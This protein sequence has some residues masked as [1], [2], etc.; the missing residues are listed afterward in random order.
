MREGGCWIFLSHSTKDIDMIRRIRNEFEILGQNPIAFH[1]RCL[2]EEYP[3]RD[4]ELWSLIHREI[5]AREWFVYCKSPDAEASEN[6][7]KERM[8]FDISGKNKIWDIDITKGWNEIKNKIHKICAD[9]EVVV[10]YSHYDEAVADVIIRVL[11]DADYAV[12]TDKNLKMDESWIL[13]NNNAI[14]RCARKGFYVV[15]ISNESIKSRYV[16]KEL[17][18]AISQGAWIIPVLV[19]NPMMPEWMRMWLGNCYVCSE[20]PVDSD[21]NSLVAELDSIILKK[22]RNMN[23]EK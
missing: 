21:F 15:L 18:Y 7:K 12:W 13:Q 4:E 5:D 11:A 16:E 22:I 9:I 17:E 2:D 6:V 10:S 3:K 1:L 8:Y 20:N 19:G 23:S 14:E